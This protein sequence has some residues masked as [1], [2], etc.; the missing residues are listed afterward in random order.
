MA[1]LTNYQ[2]LELARIYGTPV[3]I[4]N[5]E[6]LT[7]SLLAFQEAFEPLHSNLRIAYPYK[8]NNLLE[9]I[10]HFHSWGLWAE[11]TSG[12]ELS[13]AKQL[14][15][16]NDS[17]VFNGPWKSDQDLI[18]AHSLGVLV[19]I[20]N[21]SELRR[22]ERLVKSIGDR[23]YGVG[24]RLNL[25]KLT[26]TDKFGFEIEDGT[27][28]RVAQYIRKSKFL[29]LVGI[30][31]HF[32]SNV[33]DIK[34]Y[35]LLMSKLAEFTHELQ[36][37]G[38]IE[39]KFVDIGSGF[40]I[41]SPKPLSISHWEVPTL[42]EY[43]Q[44]V[45]DCFGDLDQTTQLIVEPGRTLVSSAVIL[46]ARVIAEKKASETPIVLVDAG[47]NLIPGR[48]IYDYSMMAFKKR[49]TT[50]LFD[51]YGPLCD[52]YDILGS[53]VPLPAPSTGDVLG[54]LNVG[55]YDLVRS[56]AWNFPLPPVVLLEADGSHKLIRRRGTLNDVWAMQTN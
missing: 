10:K 49:K 21:E 4:I 27:A 50:T 17:I 26:G 15:V 43:G 55:A 36:T 12:I 16:E 34:L 2:A 28:L 22:F 6:Q 19:F 42:A 32:K 41:S 24:I 8:V 35:R 31:A 13:M 54:I 1:F 20:D 30:H 3:Y 53:K 33:H 48:D 7:Q 44:V 25:S 40:A 37:M 51:V 9:V 38:L 39:P 18:L 14:S 11:V 47:V 46:L 29:K 56:F 23:K 5:R 45:L 52:T